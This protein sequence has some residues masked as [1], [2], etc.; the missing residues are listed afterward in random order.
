MATK[1]WFK[2]ETNDNTSDLLGASY[3]HRNLKPRS[4]SNVGFLMFETELPIAWGALNLWCSLG[5]SSILILPNTGIM[6][7]CCHIWCRMSFLVS[8]SQVA[9]IFISRQCIYYLWKG[10]VILALLC[11]NSSNIFKDKVNSIVQKIMNA[12]HGGT[13]LYPRP[14]E[15]ETDKCQWVWGQPIYSMQWIQ[16]SQGY[17]SFSQ[18]S[19]KP[20]WNKNS[21]TKNPPSKVTIELDKVFPRHLR[22]GIIRDT[23][24]RTGKVFMKAGRHIINQRIP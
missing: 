3:L 20:W 13:C 24:Y 1:Q 18:L 5:W 21:N 7:I 22:V 16:A 19:W 9:S 10:T 8:M 23:S 6:G 11:P 4:W 15:A 14:W 17:L 12:N 2:N